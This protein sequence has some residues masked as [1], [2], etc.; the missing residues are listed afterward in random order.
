LRVAALGCVF[1]V[2]ESALTIPGGE[3]FGD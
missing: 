3:D 1:V 2:E